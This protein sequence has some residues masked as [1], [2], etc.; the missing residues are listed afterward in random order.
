MGLFGKKVELPPP[1]PPTLVESIKEAL[2][3]VDVATHIGRRA[4]GFDG[5][6]RRGRRAHEGQGRGGRRRDDGRG[7]EGG[8]G[9]GAVVSR[10]CR[11]RPAG[12]PTLKSRPLLVYS[13]RLR[14]RSACYAWSRR[15]SRGPPLSSSARRWA[16]HRGSLKS[17]IDLSARDAHRINRSIVTQKTSAAVAPRVAAAAEQQKTR[18][19]T[20]AK[21]RRSRR[22]LTFE[23]QRDS[24]TTPQPQ[25]A[26]RYYKN[27]Q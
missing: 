15:H 25:R 16:A 7:Q 19:S 22:A 10:P 2:K 27:D 11:A 18:E 12:E 20:T 9:T 17:G 8:R 23:A 1:P 6:H 3:E 26:C 4:A 5:G 14:V 21:P 13:S 24:E